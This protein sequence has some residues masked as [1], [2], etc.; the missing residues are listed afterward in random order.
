MRS[1]QSVRLT[2]LVAVVLTA[3]YLP[4]S[5]TAGVRIAS[6]NLKHLGWNNGK[7]LQAVAQIVGRFDLVAIQEV[8]D[9]AAARR[10]AKIVSQ[11]TG[12]PWGVTT[13]QLEGDSSYRESYAFLWRKSAVAHDSGDSLY[14]DPGNKFAREP[15]TASFTTK[16]NH[17]ELTLGTVH[18]NYGD[19]RSDRTAEIRVLDQYW[20]WMGKT[21]QGHRLLMGDFNMSPKD[22]SWRALDALAVPSITSGASTLSKTDGRFAHLYDNIWHSKADRLNITARGVLHYPAI[23]GMSHKKAFATVSDHAPVYIALGKAK[24]NTA[25]AK[26]FKGTQT[27]T[28][29]ASCID[30]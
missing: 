3:L 8:M 20:Q 19:G 1:I 21:Y 2:L 22:R 28:A 4:V 11:D 16:D 27:A 15:Y 10:L 30:I 24:V 26:G 13:S 18:I 17:T 7:N 14:L 6:W 12:E 9:P 25:P 5:A 23:L 29:T